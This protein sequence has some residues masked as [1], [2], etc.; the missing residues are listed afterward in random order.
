M[1]RLRLAQ[2]ALQALLGT[3]GERACRLP[4]SDEAYDLG[5][6]GFRGDTMLAQGTARRLA[7]GGGCEQ[8]M[9]AADIAVPEPAGLLLGLNHD[10]A[11]VIGESLE[12]QRLPT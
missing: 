12:H 5:F 11:G 8:E 1:Q 9:L 2:G 7:H 3:R 4:E 10:F 6:H